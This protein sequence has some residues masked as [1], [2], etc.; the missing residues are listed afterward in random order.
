M[1]QFNQKN[2]GI[3]LLSISVILIALLGFAKFNFDK[4]GA[5]LCE[6]I[7][8]EPELDMENCPAHNTSTSWSFVAAFGIAFLVLGS[9]IYIIIV[10]KYAKKEVEFAEVDTSKLDDEEKKIYE[11]LK[12][13]QGSMY[14]SDIIKETG[15]SKVQTTRILDKLE[16]KKVLDRKRRGMTNIIVLK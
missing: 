15:F 12:Q 5:L 10:S 14:Q 2:I 16:G 4:Q 3:I 9:G 11:T 1:M 6:F 8:L 7:S 13:N